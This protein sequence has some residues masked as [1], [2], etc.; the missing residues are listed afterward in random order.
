MKIKHLFFLFQ[1][2]IFLSLILLVLFT[3]LLSNKLYAQ[4]IYFGDLHVHSELSF[5]CTVPIDLRY[6][7]A[8]YVSGLDFVLM[9]EHDHEI[10]D[11]LWQLSKLKANQYYLPDTFVTFIGYE[12]THWLGHKT[13]FYPGN[14]GKLFHYLTVNQQK[15]LDS[16]RTNGGQIIIPHPDYQWGS[17]DL[18]Q[19]DPAVVRSIEISG[20]NNH[21][22]EFFRNPNAPPNQVFGKSVQNW[23]AAD[24]MQKKRLLGFIGVSDAHDD[25]IPGSKGLTAVITDSLNRKSIFDAIKRRHT[26]ATTGGKKIILSF[27]SHKNIMGDSVFHQIGKA[28]HFKFSCIGTTDIQLIEVIKNN[29]VIH[30]FSPDNI[31][32]SAE[33]Y[34]IDSIYFTYYYLRIT[35]SDG[36]MAWSSPIY[37]FQA[38]FIPVKIE[39]SGEQNFKL[40]QNYPNPFNSS[41][42]IEFNLPIDSFIKLKIYDILGQEINTFIDNMSVA[43]IYKV[44]FDAKELNSGI[45]FYE[46]IMINNNSFQIERKKMI[47]IK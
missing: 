12:Y 13:V 11:S 36:N 14:N 35:Q 3:T 41:T 25:H 34:D 27:Q 1:F 5:D 16:V 6:Y 2:K 28:K 47:V 9:S 43:G 42:T 23:L 29:N 45:Y 15:L 20:Y 39:N 31:E 46:L 26:Y 44:Q 32:Y 8:R 7:Q 37:F 30:T 10:T 17:S 33:F 40:L 22:H 21:R 18:T 19:Y 4:N 38:D 24:W